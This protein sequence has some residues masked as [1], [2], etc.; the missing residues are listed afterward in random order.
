MRACKNGRAGGGSK[1]KAEDLNDWLRMAEIEETE[2]G[3]EG[4]GDT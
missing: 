1:M 2:E 4:K 3:F